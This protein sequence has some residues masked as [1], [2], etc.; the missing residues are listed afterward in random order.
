M[1]GYARTLAGNM[2]RLQVHS[3]KIEPLYKLVRSEVTAQ[4]Q[5]S[6]YLISTLQHS[7]GVLPAVG[8]LAIL[9]WLLSYSSYGIDF[10]DEG[11]YLLWMA[12]PF[13]YDAS[14]S[15][16]GFLYHPFYVLFDGNI[17]AL[18][19]F[20]VVTTFCLAWV[21]TYTW[22][23]ATLE[24]ETRFS[25]DKIA[26]TAGLA[27]SALVLFDEW[28]PTPSYNGLAL[29]ALLISGIGVI[30]AVRVF[31]PKSFLGWALIGISGWLAFMAKPTTALALAVGVILWSLIARK[32]SFRLGI[33][34]AF[35][36]VALVSLSVLIIDGSFSTL[37][38]RLQTGVDLARYLNP[39]YTLSSSIRLDDLR[40]P[41]RT[42]FALLI[43]L[44]VTFLAIFGATKPQMFGRFIAYLL[45]A[46]AIVVTMTLTLGLVHQAP[47]FG[48]FQGLLLFAV[49]IAVALA[50]LIASRKKC[51][52]A[53]T[54]SGFGCCFSF[55]LD[56]GH[57]R[58]WNREKL[59]G[60]RS[61]GRHLLDTCRDRVSRP[62]RS[63][64]R[65]LV[66]STVFGA[67]YRGHYSDSPPDWHPQ[68]LPPA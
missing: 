43:T 13:I 37:L 5:R 35:T 53:D 58:F 59:L 29:H 50:A 31:T 9:G 40:L 66:R 46:V 34:A 12:D 67:F 30:L 65:K 55:R 49:A 23:T 15:Q 6:T 10:T 48:R 25:F 4:Q 60:E 1:C 38:V 68:T 42:K 20:N 36:A 47:G 54:S 8:A 32:F 19:Q 17:A 14:A 39:G 51:F 33:F 52:S 41:I 21:L 44:L 18:R 26:A 56:A 2:R 16:F 63:P 27:T 45:A 11:Y 57:S 24:G 62:Y 28:L 3:I 22:A 64:A 7:F 61:V